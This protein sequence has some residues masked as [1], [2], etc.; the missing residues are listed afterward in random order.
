MIGI[1]AR[2]YVPPPPQISLSKQSCLY[3]TNLFLRRVTAELL[4][5][6]FGHEEMKLGK[7]SSLTAKGYCTIL[8]CAMIPVVHYNTWLERLLLGP[9]YQK[10]VCF[11]AT[12]RTSPPC[13]KMNKRSDVF[14]LWEKWQLQQ[15]WLLPSEKCSFPQCLVFIPAS[16]NFFHINK[17]HNYLTTF[18]I[19]LD[20]VI[21]SRFCNNNEML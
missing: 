21:M 7:C 1:L 19:L 9:S 15:E 11:L 17:Y 13:W 4:P 12:Y 16:V 20:T 18:Q 10:F 6:L 3:L 2:K 5:F 8:F 14:V